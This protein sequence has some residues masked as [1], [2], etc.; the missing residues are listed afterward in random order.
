MA[1]LQG[2]AVVAAAVVARTAWTMTTALLFLELAGAVAVVAQVQQTPAAALGV[3][4]RASPVALEQARLPVVEVV[5]EVR[6][7]VESIRLVVAEAVV[8]R[9][10][11]QAQLVTLLAV[12]L[13]EPEALAELLDRLFPAT[14]ILPTLQQEQGWGQSY[15]R[16]YLYL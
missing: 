15:D 8:A 13:R 11:Q 12:Q 4:H 3:F 16:H 5:A 7:L 14:Q 9:T 6:H 10:A 2:A 1:P